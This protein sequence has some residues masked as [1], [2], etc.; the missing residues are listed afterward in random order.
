VTPTPEQEAGA[1]ESQARGLRTAL[2]QIEKRL[3]TL[4][5]EDA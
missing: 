3:Q 4:K 5:G 1:L 2:E